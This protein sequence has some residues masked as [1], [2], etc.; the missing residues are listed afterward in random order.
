MG[1]L[2]ADAVDQVPELGARQRVYA[3][4]GLVENEQI[5]VVDQCAAQ[6]QLLLHAARELACRARQKFF[7]AGALRQIVDAQAAL[8]LVMPEQACKELQVFLD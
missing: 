4:G 7:Q 2:A 3:G 8:G 5:R 1:A 6:G